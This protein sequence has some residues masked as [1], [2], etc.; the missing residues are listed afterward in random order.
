MEMGTVMKTSPHDFLR[1]A[2]CAL[3][4]VVSSKA[5]AVQPCTADT[6]CK[7]S[8]VCRQGQCTAPTACGRDRDCPGEEICVAA[9]CSMAPIEQGPAAAPAPAF[10]PAA[11]P[12]A[13]PVASTE[14]PPA[15]SAEP[16]T[17]EPPVVP[18]SPGPPPAI[19][20]SSDRECPGDL[21]C[22]SRQC[23]ALKKPASAAQ[24]SPTVG[25]SAR[26]PRATA[27]PAASMGLRF[28]PTQDFVRDGA[29]NIEW[30]KKPHAELLE[31]VDAQKYCAELYPGGGR[32]RLPNIEELM[33]LTQK[34]ML[35]QVQAAFPSLSGT[36][37]SSSEKERFRMWAANLRFGTKVVQSIRDPSSVLCVR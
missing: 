25:A 14:P 35:T 20:C 18:P 6:D 3:V 24:P 7:R 2:V 36:F 10:T 28:S 23:V 26:V 11:E 27:S 16:A 1:A 34:A 21:L 22:E 19:R 9:V 17:D 31:F 37:W 12:A 15:P 33:S 29:L 5:L 32:W 30:Q 13:A 4:L 8:R